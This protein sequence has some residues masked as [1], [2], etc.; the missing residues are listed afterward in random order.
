MSYARR[1]PDSRSRNRIKHAVLFTH[2]YHRECQTWVL[3]R[4]IYISCKAGPSSWVKRWFVS[5]TDQNARFLPHGRISICLGL[6]DIPNFGDS[7]AP[8]LPGHCQRS[9][10]SSVFLLVTPPEASAVKVSS[11]FRYFN[12]KTSR[13]LITCTFAG[14]PEPRTQLVSIFWGT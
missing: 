12:F 3:L 6:K 5:D 14:F 1:L 8:V 7:P 2:P 13:L 11:S 9:I 10:L 4:R